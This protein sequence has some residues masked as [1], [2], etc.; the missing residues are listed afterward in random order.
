MGTQPNSENNIYTYRKGEKVYLIKEKDQIVVREIP[1]IIERR[2][3]GG[4]LERVSPQSTRIK[5]KRIDL[6]SI[7]G[8]IRKESVAHHAYKQVNNGSEFLITDRIMITFKEDVGN[9][10]LSAFLAKYALILVTK[11]SNREF[12]LRL[13]DQTGMNPL[14]LVVLINETENTLI[15]SC[16]HDLNQ[17]MTISDL[18][19]PSDPKYSQQWHL[20]KRFTDNSFD[21]R[22]SSNCEEAWMLLN[23]YGD[24]E[25]VIAVT[26]DGCKLDH[27]DFNSVNKFANWA[28]MQ[29]DTLV[30]RDSVSANSLNMYQ[31]GAD[32]GTNC[33]G[34]VAADV[35]G[36]LTVGAAPDCRLLPIKWES[37]GRSLF[38]G[39][40]KMMTMLDFVADKVDVVSNSWGRSP[41]SNYA[42][43]VINRIAQL[44]QTGG[45]RGKG[46]VFLWAS[47]NENCPIKY[48]GN[49]DI[50]YTSGYHGFSWVG[51][52]TS[53]E[54]EHNL[55]GIPGVM[56]IAAIASN[57][58]RSH[59]S[60]YGEG[61]SLC[62]PSSN[63]HAYWR[64]E[65]T[66]LG[67]LTSTGATPFFSSNFGG[68]S[69]ATP[70][71]AGIAGLII[72]ANPNLS[73]LEVISILQ[74]TA[75]KNL[76][77]LK[78]A[79]TPPNNRDR[80][81]SW[82]I[83]PINPYN[84]G[85]FNNVGHIDGTWSGWFGFGKVDAYSAVA[86]ALR[87]NE[88]PDSNNRKIIQ[89]SS[90][91]KVIPD[92]NPVG[93]T[94]SITINHQ[95]IIKSIS[96]DLD[97]KHPYIGD[98]IVKLTSPKGVF[99]MLHDRKGGN[100]KYISKTFDLQNTPTLSRYIGERT[101]G[102][103]TLHV[104]DAAANDI[105]K[106]NKWTVEIGVGSFKE[107]EFEDN[108]GVIIPDNNPEGI[109]R[110][111][112]VT[113]YGTIK[114]IKLELDITHTYIS[115]LIVNLVSPDGTVVNI[116]RRTGGSADNI[117]RNYDYSSLPDLLRLKGLETQGI[118][119]LQVSDVSGKDVG[120]LNKWSIKIVMD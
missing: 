37:I 79:Q 25:V 93:I 69:S 36:T 80:D 89:S 103:W 32:H 68:T 17:R 28:Y 104:I 77:M 99:A 27:T 20:H 42:S 41:I 47:G 73:A 112:N 34:V 70:L 100:S 45:R 76:N 5:L 54:F 74:R 96:V 102:T 63:S 23:H 44:G 57:A 12:L 108:P 86:E 58:Q 35:D 4:P 71:V 8:D 85:D 31:S 120:K 43:N 1:E 15:E 13:T 7:L 29:G 95:G 106:L 59:Y 38:I 55:I 53:R 52:Q 61:I 116:H 64:M 94:D 115:D 81:T 9:D 78:Y 113:D 67:I 40:S 18:Q 107:I 49:L 117:I 91:S 6:D 84:V 60:N 109:E 56:Y 14:K 119:K 22:S 51:V 75:S 10:V 90:P 65:V 97:I 62:A 88:F 92:N 39:D 110:S 87:T 105:G 2:G 26:D 11:Y 24:S 3:L 16:E 111:L 118:W 33:C 82:D 66:G 46:I 98:L 21:P 50:P 83:S 19:L 101:S 114:E 72:S 30:H 48:S